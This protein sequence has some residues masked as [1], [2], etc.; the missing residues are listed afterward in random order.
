MCNMCVCVRVRVYPFNYLTL[1]I[2]RLYWPEHLRISP[3]AYVNLYVYIPT[4][5]CWV[6]AC[7]TWPWLDVMNPLQCQ[8]GHDS[9]KLWTRY[10][11]LQC[12]SKAAVLPW[13]RN[14]AQAARRRTSPGAA[15]SFRSSSSWGFQ[16]RDAGRL[17]YGGDFLIGTVF[18][19][20]LPCVYIG[21]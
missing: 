1:I 20:I 17:K 16:I 12:Q 4:T 21:L 10:S 15:L 6:H 18:W 5:I 7:S 2:C 13:S 11:K 8:R 9:G 14:L 19:G 3:H